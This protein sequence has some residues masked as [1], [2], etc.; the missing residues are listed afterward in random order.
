[1]IKYIFIYRDVV[2]KYEKDLR[3]IFYFKKDNYKYIDKL[4]I[5]G[6]NLF[7]RDNDIIDDFKIDFLIY[8]DTS[9][10]PPIVT[11]ICMYAER[12]T[13]SYDNFIFKLVP[14]ITIIDENKFIYND[15][16]FIN[17]IRSNKLEIG[18]NIIELKIIDDGI[19]EFDNSYLYLL[20]NL[21]FNVEK[22]YLFYNIQKPIDNL[23]FSIK[24]LFVYD[25]C[26]MDLIKIPFNCEVIKIKR[27][28]N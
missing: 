14:I 25:N 2:S 23:P 17:T 16:M 22:L 21:P 5:Y 27:Y 28:F 19:L 20:D 7:L 4:A 11:P 1:M 8:M 6:L 9:S 26:D 3:Y 13:V 18:E 12:T 15:I 24:K 10:S